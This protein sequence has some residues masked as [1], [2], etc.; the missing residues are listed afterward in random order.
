M[1]IRA[2]VMV[3]GDG[4]ASEGAHEDE[5]GADPGGELGVSGRG[6]EGNKRHKKKKEK[7]TDS[8]THRLKMNERTNER[9]AR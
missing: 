4:D 1:R 3:R 9:T 2:R 8:Q 6:F 7:A 5:Y